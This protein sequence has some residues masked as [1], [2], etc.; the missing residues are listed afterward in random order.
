M[1]SP[2]V[3]AVDRALTILAAFEGESEAMTLAALARRTGL[4]KSTLL[5]LMTSLQQFGYLLQLRDGRYQL[6]P[7]PFRLGAV[8]QRANRL[9]DRVVP[10]LRQLVVA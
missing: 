4:Y 9:H 2:G 6:G 10:V 8:Y 1:S 3:A 5:R 7:M